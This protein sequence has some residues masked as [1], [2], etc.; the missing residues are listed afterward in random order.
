MTTIHD[1]DAGDWSDVRF[2]ANHGE[3]A[4]TRWHD[5]EAKSLA[6]EADALAKSL[7]PGA[8]Q[9][10]RFLASGIAESVTDD[11]MT[12]LWEARLVGY[13]PDDPYS[14]RPLGF[15]IVRVLEGPQ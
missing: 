4:A 15:E 3:V 14:V 9:T 12:E 10:L 5:N 11:A 6:S 2:V 8:V 1:L 13:P 7:S